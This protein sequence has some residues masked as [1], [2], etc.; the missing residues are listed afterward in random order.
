MQPR[1]PRTGSPPEL[2][3][4]SPTEAVSQAKRRLQWED[5]AICTNKSSSKPRS[6]AKSPMRGR[7]AARARP[8]A[9]HPEWRGKRH[10]GPRQRGTPPVQKAG[11]G[12]S[13]TAGP[14]L[15]V[16]VGRGSA[17]AAN[18]PHGAVHPR[19]KT[20]R[21]WDPLPQAAVDHQRAAQRLRPSLARPLEH[22]PAAS[23]ITAGTPQPTRVEPASAPPHRSPSRPQSG[24]SPTANPRLPVS[25]PAMQK[26]QPSAG[27]P[28]CGP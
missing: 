28:L 27:R 13:R 23:S 6:T 19:G 21:S 18:H 3:T 16:H 20:T 7:S 5:E 10:V 11:G 22:P 24:S 17:R 26:P 25:A 8:A 15:L 4:S 1:T 12:L 9:S 2:P 14:D